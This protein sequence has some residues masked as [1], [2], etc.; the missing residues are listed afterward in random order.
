MV[1]TPTKIALLEKQQW[2]LERQRA[3]LAAVSI[4]DEL[5]EGCGPK[6]RAYLGRVRI[7]LSRKL[8]AVQLA[9]NLNPKREDKNEKR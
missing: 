3:L 2:L 4:I 8:N 5:V 1:D 7:W 9:L 6:G